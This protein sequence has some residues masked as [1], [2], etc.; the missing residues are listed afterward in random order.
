LQSLDIGG[1]NDEDDGCGIGIVASPVRPNAGLTTKILHREK[2][3]VSCRRKH[4]NKVMSSATYPNIEVEILVCHRLDIETNGGNS[5]DDFANLYHNV[6]ATSSPSGTM[7][8]PRREGSDLE[9]VEESCLSGVILL[10]TA[11]HQQAVERIARQ[12]PAS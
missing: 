8:A 9:S 7:Y 2:C 12:L 1:V 5:C 3:I 10:G 4:R 11:P 6:N